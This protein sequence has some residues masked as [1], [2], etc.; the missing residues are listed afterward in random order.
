[1]AVGLDGCAL[2]PRM[3]PS[4]QQFVAQVMDMF[5]VVDFP[6][7]GYDMPGTVTQLHLLITSS[8]LDLRLVA[9]CIL[10]LFSRCKD[11]L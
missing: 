8:A 10:Y 11:C 7:A 2:R 5:D 4:L 1:M 3:L 9:S 6:V